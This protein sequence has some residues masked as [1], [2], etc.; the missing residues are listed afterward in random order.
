MSIDITNIWDEYDLGGLEQ[1][2]SSLFPDKQFH[3]EDMFSQILSGDV[4]GGIS[5]GIQSF[6]SA[7]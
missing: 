2:L 5:Y 3:L 1:K 7:I 4:M 6:L